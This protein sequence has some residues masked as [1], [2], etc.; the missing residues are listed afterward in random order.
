MK[1]VLIRHLAPSIE[2]GICYGRMD[3]PPD[4]AS[5]AQL[6]ALATHPALRAL[7]THPAL[8]ALATHPA[9]RALATH[10]A[11]PG[12][13]VIRSSP[14]RRCHMMAEELAR[15]WSAA[16]LTDLRLQE[17]DFGDWEGKPWDAI[18]R[19]ALDLWAASPLTF[20][21][22]GGETGAE[23]VAR[24]AGFYADLLQARQDCI[25]VSHGGPL[26]VL[27]ALLTGAAVDLLAP[28]PSFGSVNV[29]SCPA[30]PAPARSVAGG[31]RAKA[32][33]RDAGDHPLTE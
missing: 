14:A 2:P 19:A 31:G 6:P 30:V 12:T 16:L 25:V 1:I 24:V 23:L 3:I 26:K 15:I 9:L 8:R 33:R 4:P 27:A 28:A 22:P 29:V 7:A 21:P 13:A 5:F 11:L 32:E 10:P 18:D 20:A 17:L